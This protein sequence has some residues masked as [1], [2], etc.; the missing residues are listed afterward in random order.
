MT[1]H[2]SFPHLVGLVFGVIAAPAA[3]GLATA[4]FILAN[5]MEGELE[6]PD[7][8]VHAVLAIPGGVLGF[9]AGGVWDA[10]MRIGRLLGSGAES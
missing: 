3:A 9:L 4:V 10:V 5:G 8:M 2:P 6:G 1:R 7:L